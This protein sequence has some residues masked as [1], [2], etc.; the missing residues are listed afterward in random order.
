MLE[1]HRL[2][3]VWYR[4]NKRDLPWR[5]TKNPYYIWLSEVVL[6]QTRVAQGIA[7]YNKFVDE[8]PTIHHLAQAD[9]Q[10]VL[11]LWQGLG[12]YSRARNLHAT[13]KTIVNEYDGVFPESFDKIKG[14]KG[15]G[16]YTAS[17]IASF[18]YDLPYP[19]IDGN[20]YRVLSRVFDID[21]PIDS[22]EGKKKFKELAF[23]V[24]DQNNPAEYNQAIMEFGA[25]QCVPKSPNC[26][27]C[28]VNSSCLSFGNNTIADRPVKSKKSKSVNR[29]FHF[30]LSDNGKLYLQKRRGKDIWQHLYQF[31]LIET[32]EEIE[33]NLFF[34]KMN[35]NVTSLLKV[36]VLKKHVLSHQNLFAKIYLMDEKFDFK[37]M[38]DD[39]IEI[40]KEVLDDF[41]LPRLIEKFLEENVF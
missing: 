6:Q 25:L 18:S 39:V 5:R 23:E 1:F 36:F 29:Y 35:F 7:Y 4:Q 30:F 17:A 16:E 3:T 13:A 12:Y 31:P 33:E 32:K 20:V 15:I 28:P 38:F 11:R 10:V 40:E 22:S 14:L 8:F 41:P 27:I 34:S 37:L 2:I 19:V 9:E 24:F 26:E 21:L